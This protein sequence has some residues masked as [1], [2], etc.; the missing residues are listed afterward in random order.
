MREV[1][2]INVG[3][4]VYARG[5]KEDIEEQC[6]SFNISID[7]EELNRIQD[8]VIFGLEMEYWDIIN[9]ELGI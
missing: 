5:I 1:K 9:K 8:R 3:S 4:Y 2:L 6:K 7:G